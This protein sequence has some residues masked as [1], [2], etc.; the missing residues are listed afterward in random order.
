MTFGLLFTASMA[1]M[2]PLMPAGPMLRASIPSSKE[3]STCPFAAEAPEVHLPVRGGG[4][5]QKDDQALGQGT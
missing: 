1:P 2:R 5:C 4:A 3:K